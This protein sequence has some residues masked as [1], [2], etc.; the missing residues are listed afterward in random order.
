MGY[1][2]Y[3][4]TG[5]SHRFNTLVQFAPA[6]DTITFESS[7]GSSTMVYTPAAGDTGLEWAMDN[8]RITLT[9]A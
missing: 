9:H 6:F 2:T 1:G 5:R 3:L 8:M 7:E 4:Y